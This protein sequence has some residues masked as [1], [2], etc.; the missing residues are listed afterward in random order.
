MKVLFFAQSR[1]AAGCGTYEL[2]V[3]RALTSQE[4]WARLVAEF[5]R[6]VPIQKTA[7]L[8]RDESYLGEGELLKPGDEVAVIPPV[9]G[10]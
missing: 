8:A 1:E 5:P 6:L 10:G 3:D 4:F 2:E 7:R 9:S